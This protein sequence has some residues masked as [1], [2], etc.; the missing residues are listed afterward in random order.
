MTSILSKLDL[1][2]SC[3]LNTFGKRIKALVELEA[4]TPPEA[5]ETAEKELA[6]TPV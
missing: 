4:E 6:T 5:T 3:D 1:L 2:L